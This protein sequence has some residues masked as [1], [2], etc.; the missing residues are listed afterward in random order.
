MKTSLAKA[1]KFAKK[2][3]IF[4]DGLEKYILNPIG[5]RRNIPGMNNR[6]LGALGVLGER[7]T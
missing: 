5:R 3:Q 4:F 7:S 6:L 2:R 1:A